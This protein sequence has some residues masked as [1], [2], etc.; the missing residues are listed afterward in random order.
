MLGEALFQRQPATG[1]TLSEF[2][3]RKLPE[4]RA[5]AAALAAFQHPSVPHEAIG[6]V[7]FGYFTTL[8]PHYVPG[9]MRRMAERHPRVTLSVTEGDIGFL[10]RQL[11]AGRIELALT[12]DVEISP[13]LAI[14]TVAELRPY[15]LLPGDHPLARATAVDLRALA[16]YPFILVDLPFSREFLVSVFRA[17]GIE[18]RISHRARSLEMVF[19][20]VANGLGVSVLVTRRADALSYDGKRVVARP[21]LESR[22]RQGVV[23]AWAQGAAL[24][25][26]AQALADCVREELAEASRDLSDP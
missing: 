16:A 8:G 19:G 22:V 3:R 23:L 18:P 10:T 6:Q 5:I 17:E 14:E 13:A 4:A 25:P 24:S 2:G 12:Y 11:A 1:L 15:A 9:V 21:L 7:A 20:M 26:P